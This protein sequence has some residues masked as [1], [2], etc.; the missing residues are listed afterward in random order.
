MKKGRKL[1]LLRS[2]KKKKKEKKTHIF[3]LPADDCGNE[4][5]G[6]KKMRESRLGIKE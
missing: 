1:L 5:A 2:R 3:K 4:P 6:W